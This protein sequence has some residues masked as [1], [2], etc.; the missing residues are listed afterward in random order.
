M[1]TSILVWTE[2][3]STA[4]KIPFSNL[5]GIVWTGPEW[6]GDAPIWVCMHIKSIANAPK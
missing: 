3:V 6:G 1:D 5:S 4:T 2:G